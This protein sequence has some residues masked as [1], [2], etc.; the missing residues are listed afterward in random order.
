[1]NRMNRRNALKFAATGVGLAGVLEPTAAEGG[2]I[3]QQADPPAKYLILS[4][5]GGGMRGVL[6]ALIIKQLNDQLPFLDRVSLFAGTSTG[7]IIALGLA[8]SMKPRDVV[9]W[10]VDRGALIFNRTRPKPEPSG[11]IGRFWGSVKSHA[12]EFAKHLGFKLDELLRAR[13]SNEGLKKALTEV[14]G[15]ATFQDLK[16]GR[17]ALVTTLRLSSDKKSWAPL[18]LHNLPMNASKDTH[19]EDGPTP[20]TRLV[21]AAMCSSAAPLYFPPHLHPEFGYCIDGGVFANC[22]ASIALALAAR[23]NK[24]KNVS[25]RM[26]SIGTGTQLNSIDIPSPPFE[27]PEEFGALAWLSPIARGK[28]PDGGH[29][30]PAFPLISA[31]LE[32]GSA[33]HSYVCKQALGDDYHRVQVQLAKSIP[34]DATDVDSRKRIHEAAAKLF[35]SPNW[36]ATVAWL[37]HQLT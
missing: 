26:L 21:D 5:D 36:H 28:I 19:V 6:T 1:M 20:S 14:F 12:P 27:T 33:S 16:P 11:R 31:L 37:R 29:R 35:E 15:D 4:C 8:N 23:A 17:A 10:Y 24:G 30:T 25:P 9:D 18:V 2:L 3:G 13:Y 32:A 22:P 34:L 7:A